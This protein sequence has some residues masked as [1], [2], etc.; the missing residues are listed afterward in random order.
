MIV[1][2]MSEQ[3]AGMTEGRSPLR[4]SLGYLANTE[5]SGSHLSPSVKLD[6]SLSLP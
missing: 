6:A 5:R 4:D 2:E 1:Q 3:F